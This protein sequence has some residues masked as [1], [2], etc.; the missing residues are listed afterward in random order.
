MNQFPVEFLTGELSDDE[1]DKAI[2]KMAAALVIE[3]IKERQNQGKPMK[4][5]E[6][7]LPEFRQMLIDSGQFMP[8]QGLDDVIELKP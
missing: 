6:F 8:Y 3:Q 4:W 7:E 1:M 2:D 5:S